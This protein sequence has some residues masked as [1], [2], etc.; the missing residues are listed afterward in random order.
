MKTETAIKL[1][2]SREALALILGCAPIT[3]Y[4][5]KPSLPQSREDRLRILKPRWFS[6]AR[7][8]AIEKQE[9]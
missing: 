7:I 9:A 2:G 6:Q 4:R 5:W 3:T 8:D 1:A